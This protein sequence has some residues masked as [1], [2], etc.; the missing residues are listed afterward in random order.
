M[1]EVQLPY[2][3]AAD[4]SLIPI[5]DA[6][7]GKACDCSCPK[8]HR[9]LVARQG[10]RQRWCFAHEAHESCVGAYETMLHL[11]AK[12]ILSLSKEVWQPPV[13]G[14]HE[15]KRVLLFQAVRI[16]I[17]RVEIEP[18]I[19]GIRPDVVV[20][21]N[22]RSIAVEVRVTHKVGSEKWQRLQDGRIESF[23]LDL[24]GYTKS[25]SP[26]EIERAVVKEGPRYW[27]YSKFAD[28]CRKSFAARPYR[29]DI[30]EYSGNH[31]QLVI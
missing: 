10:E 17:D 14:Y 28:Q 30:T 29:F 22:G 2:G 6:V 25:L 20:S 16:P 27:V 7:R 4:G 3:M 15:G 8:C 1:R 12:Q 9:P 26:E 18:L 19:G 11:V 31:L 13:L 5:N 21:I 24:S 23:E